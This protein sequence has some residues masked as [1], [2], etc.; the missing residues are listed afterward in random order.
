MK[1][2]LRMRQH[3]WLASLVALLVVVVGIAFWRLAP[4][5]ELTP[6]PPEKLVLGVAEVLNVMPVLVAEEQGFLRDAGLDVTTRRFPSGNAALDALFRGEVEAA[7]VGE[8][9]AVRASFQRRDFV[10]VGSFLS[11][12]AGYYSL[13]HPASG[14]AS[15]A[16]LR[17]RRVGVVAGTTAEYCLHVLLTDHGLSEA[18]IVKVP[19]TGPQMADALFNRRVDVI[20]GMEPYL[21]H[22]QKALGNTGLVLLDR[23]RCPS[24]VGYFTSRDFPRQRKEALVRLL[25]GTGQ[26]IDWMRS[27]R[28]EAIA[29]VAR[30]LDIAPADLEAQWDDYRFVLELRQSDLVALEQQAEWAMR[31]GQ[32]P[33]APMPN[34]LDF[35]DFTALAALK[36]RAI[37]VIR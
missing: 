17:G 14:I 32:A 27:H 20:A 34:Y 9:P 4:E 26:A 19:L 12:D 18:D 31:S 28:Q 1:L 29:L 23:D 35:I 15:A 11:T 37:N 5:K 13:A 16:G 24:T 6:G 10:L 2:A 22:A 30:R 7:T 25:R 21:T 36:P 8:T 3:P 33:K